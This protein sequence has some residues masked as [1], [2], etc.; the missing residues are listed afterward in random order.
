MKRFLEFVKEA[1]QQV[2]G[3]QYGSNAGGV[4]VDDKSGE[5]FYVKHYKNPDQAKAE[6]LAGKIYKHMGIHTLE[7]EMH[8]ESSVKTK[9][10]DDVKVQHPKEY[11]KPSKEHANQLGKIYHASILTKN[12]D[13]VGLE[14]DNIVKNHKTGDLHMIDHGG[15]FHFR[16]QGG[17]KDFG[18]DIAEKE[19]LRND[20]LPSGHVFNSAF[21]HHPDAE[22]H[23]LAAVKNIDDKHVKG[24]FQNSGL[25]NWRE[26]HKN[27][28]ERK[29]AL[30]KSYE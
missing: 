29:K 5:K 20:K 6:V 11:S 14:H 26:L 17:H 16:A 19:S 8:G 7:P 12:W 9:W 24:L 22:H 13:S 1:L 30:L 18:P 2:Q 15:A 23:G 27:F 28:G 25:S 21:K 10:N 4:Y 3:T